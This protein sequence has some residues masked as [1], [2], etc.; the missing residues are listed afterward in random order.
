[1]K[2]ENTGTERLFKNPILERLTRTH[3]AVPVSI[4]AIYS[5]VL[6]YYSMKYTTT[7]IGLTIGLFFL[8]VFIF[9]WVEYQVHRHLFH[10]STHTEQ[11][12]KFQYTVHGVHHHFPK[13]KD[14]L[15]MPPLL[16]ITLATLLF[17]LLRLLIGNLVFSLLPGFLVAYAFYLL[18]HYMVHA[19]RPPKNAFKA[20][21]ISHSV[22]H[23]KDG[24][25]A[26]GVTSP[27][28]DYIYGTHYQKKDISNMPAHE[29]HHHH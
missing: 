3:I 14:R 20:L 7:S 28:W 29:H 10:I 25:I 4:F 1:M 26:F 2:P 16:S 11:R 23:Y 6:L 5:M 27:F 9:T 17:L 13:D 19:H 12:K 15:A 18:V 21:W 24:E 22:H 8:G